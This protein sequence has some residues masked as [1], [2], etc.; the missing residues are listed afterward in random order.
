MLS[1]I[2]N[3]GANAINGNHRKQSD[4]GL[5]DFFKEKLHFAV[6]R[7]MQDFIVGAPSEPV[8]WSMVLPMSHSV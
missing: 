4:R 2:A 6:G 3:E 7:T 8:H 5:N 1:A